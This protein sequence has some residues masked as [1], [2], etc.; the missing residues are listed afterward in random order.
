MISSTPKLVLFANGLQEVTYTCVFCGAMTV[1]S[2]K[3]DE[4]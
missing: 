4:E 3:P 1:Y 2:I